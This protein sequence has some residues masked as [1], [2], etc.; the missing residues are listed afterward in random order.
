[1]KIRVVAFIRV[2]LCP[3][4]VKNLRK[5]ERFSLDRFRTDRDVIVLIFRRRDVASLV[6]VRV[7]RVFGD[8]KNEEDLTEE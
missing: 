4:V 5:G 2:N 1:V 6:S 8:S 7:I 3:S